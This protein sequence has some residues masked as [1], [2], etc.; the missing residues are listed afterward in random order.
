[1]KRILY[2]CQTEASANAKFKELVA[3]HNTDAPAGGRSQAYRRLWLPNGVTYDVKTVSSD[4][5]GMSCD[6]IIIDEYAELDEDQISFYKSLER[7]SSMLE[8][9]NITTPYTF[10]MPEAPNWKL[11]IG[12]GSAT[13]LQMYL[14]KA[15]NWF[16]RKMYWLVFGVTWSKI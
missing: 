11:E 16:Q 6:Q 3:A 10:K 8:E 1:M 14:S 9:P 12:E 2:V 4:L 7:P 13:Y 15:P 5:R